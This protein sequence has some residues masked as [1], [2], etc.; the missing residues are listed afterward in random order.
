MGDDKFKLWGEKDPLIKRLGSNFKLTEVRFSVNWYNGLPFEVLEFNK[1]VKD[2]DDFV[3]KIESISSHDA[4]ERLEVSKSIT[5][6]VENS[7]KYRY[8]NQ[9]PQE[10]TWEPPVVKQ[11]ISSRLQLAGLEL[12]ADNVDR[13]EERRLSVGNIDHKEDVLSKGY[14][15]KISKY[16]GQRYLLFSKFDKGIKMDEEGW[17]SATPE[18]IAEHHAYRCG[19]GVVVDCFTGVGGNAIRFAPKTTHVIA[20]DINPNKIECA[21]HNASIYGVKD[22]I[23]FIKGDSFSLAP[24]LKADTIFLSPPWGG[25]DYSESKIFDI[26]T[27]LKPHSGKH[28]FNVAKEIAP[29]MVMYLPKNS[30]ISQLADLALSARP[31][32]KLEVEKN[33]INDKLKAI[34]AYFT[35]PL[36]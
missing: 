22:R 20:I 34:T 27:M 35:K 14:F 33:V 13:S 9:K 21:Q 23:E 7:K 5:C 8:C 6:F 15:S 26:N 36:G 30:D 31:P 28:L 24:K 25:P 18:C 32:W 16:W 1:N 19:G 10:S 11:K 12:T 29:R 3:N 17:F 2:E 4:P